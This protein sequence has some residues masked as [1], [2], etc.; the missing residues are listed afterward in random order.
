MVVFPAAVIYILCAFGV[1]YLGRTTRIGAI[2][3]TL[4]AL[5]FS[6]L[7]MLLAV[8]LLRTADR[9]QPSNP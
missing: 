7:L 8:L 5:I 9:A 1:G 6:P 4:L 3:V 2:G